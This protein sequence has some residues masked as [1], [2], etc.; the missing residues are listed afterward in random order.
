M[1]ASSSNSDLEY[2]HD[3]TTK[4]EDIS[5]QNQQVIRL[6]TIAVPPIVVPR[7]YECDDEE[8]FQNAEA[9]THIQQWLTRVLCGIFRTPSRRQAHRAPNF[10]S[11][12][13]CSTLGIDK[14]VEMGSRAR[15]GL[16]GA[17]AQ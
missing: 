11:R 2:A 5:K 10:D 1:V 16:R 17:G 4:A 6:A 14:L 3:Y 7:E 12:D 8:R 13:G 9:N 15:V